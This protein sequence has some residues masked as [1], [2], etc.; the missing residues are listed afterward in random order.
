NPNDMQPTVQLLAPTGMGYDLS[1]GGAGVL[2]MVMNGPPP[3]IVHGITAPDHPTVQGITAL[4]VFNAYPVTGDG[5]VIVR[6]G[7][8]TLGG[9]KGIGGGHRVAV[10]E[11]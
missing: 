5:Q 3:V 9:A 8:Y 4:G 1:V 7:N 10:A 2:G 11:R 6:E